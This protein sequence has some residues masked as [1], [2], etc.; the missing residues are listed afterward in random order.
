M[1][2]AKELILVMLFWRWKDLDRPHFELA[3][4]LYELVY[5][6]IN[7]FLKDYL[8]PM[9]ILRD[10]QVIDYIDSYCPQYK[11]L[12]KYASDELKNISY[13]VAS[14][15]DKLSIELSRLN[16]KFNQKPW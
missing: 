14:N 3:I 13:S 12:T 6:E 15:K 2:I 10:N 11:Y 4:N 1:W 9:I 16:L 7:L 5:N 8:Q